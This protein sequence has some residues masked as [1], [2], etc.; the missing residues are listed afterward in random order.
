MHWKLKVVSLFARLLNHYW[1]HPG[2]PGHQRLGGHVL[3]IT[4]EQVQLFGQL[5]RI[6]FLYY[7]AFVLCRL[8]GPLVVYVRPLCFIEIVFSFIWG[9]L[10]AEFVTLF[11]QNEP[12]L[13]I[14]EIV[15]EKALNPT[16][17][18]LFVLQV[19]EV[20]ANFDF[21]LKLCHLAKSFFWD[22]LTIIAVEYKSSVAEH[23]LRFFY[24]K[25]AF[26]TSLLQQLAE[27]L[28]SWIQN[29]LL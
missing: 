21:S 25:A 8:W 19:L 18:L 28:L 11:S 17:Y 20:H 7:S 6:Y 16:L 9:I 29:F 24:A 13:V 12:P 4:V 3:V 22:D 10:S 2:P 27:L 1:R 23:G 15:F 26:L 5:H 14:T